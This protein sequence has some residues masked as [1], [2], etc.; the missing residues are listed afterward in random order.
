MLRRNLVHFWALM[1]GVAVFSPAISRA[2]TL[3]A[4]FTGS[5]TSV[6]PHLAAEVD[7]SLT[8]NTLTV[9]LTNT[10]TQAATDNGNILTAVFWSDSTAI[11]GTLSDGGRDGYR[12]D[13]GAVGLDG[14]GKRACSAMPLTPA[15]KM[16][17]MLCRQRGWIS[18]SPIHCWA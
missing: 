12:F 5:D 4:S 7:F 6:S 9:T 16:A 2:N 8:G 10:A 18:T 3:T 17:V 15:I 14:Q 13:S 11:G 1:A